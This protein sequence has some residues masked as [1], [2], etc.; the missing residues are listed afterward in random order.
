MVSESSITKGFCLLL[1]KL[2]QYKFIIS[3]CSE[4]A[5]RVK[6][7]PEEEQKPHRKHVPGTTINYS[8]TPIFIFLVAIIFSACSATK[9]LPANDALYKGAEIK[10][11]KIA[12]SNKIHTRQLKSELNELLRPEPNATVLGMPLEVMMHNFF[13]TEKKKGLTAWLQRILGEPPVLASSVN[14]EKNRQILENRLENKGFFSATV[15]VD[16]VV[17]NKKM[18]ATY[19]AGLNQQY[20]IRSVHFPADTGNLYEIIRTYGAKNSLLKVGD[21]YDLETIKSERATIDRHLKEFGYYYFSPDYLIV[22]VDSTEGNHQVDMFIR[23]KKDVPAK[24]LNVYRINEIEIFADYNAADSVIDTYTRDSVNGYKIIDPEH[25][26]I[27]DLFPKVLTFN[28]GDLYNRTAHNQSL[29]RVVSLGTYKFV[30]ARFGETDTTAVPSLNTFY[31]LTPAQRKSIYFE[32]SGLSKSNNSNGG[33]F[34]ISWRHRNIFKRAELFNISLFAGSERQVSSQQATVN[35]DRYGVDVNLIIPRI[36]PKVP[37]KSYSNFLPKTFINAGYEWFRRTTQYTLTSAKASYGYIWKQEITKQHQL[38]FLSLNLVQPTDIT[39]EYQAEIDTN[40]T[41][42]RAIEKQFIIGTVYNFNYNSQLRANRKKNKYYFNG[43]I[44]LYGN[45][46]G[47]ILKGDAQ[48][49]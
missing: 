11:D 8:Y 48:S 45:L 12:D 32:V 24:A 42:A 7:P 26:F 29:N 19:I 41:L 27:P 22:D 31:Y 15:S 2:L 38:S 49:G 3:I 21:P 4:A 6:C 37:I 9:H 47:L 30:K 17:N 14:L 18:K 46:A 36:I 44:D 25:K 20:R 43:K 16:T 13:Y 1:H 5:R 10:L 34:K 28:T 40:I 23:L 39:P 33:E 35:T